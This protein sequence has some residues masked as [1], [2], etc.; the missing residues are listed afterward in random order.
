ML[1]KIKKYVEIATVYFKDVFERD[2]IG[3]IK[4]FVPA[5]VYFM[6]NYYIFVSQFD[7]AEFK[8][9]NNSVPNLEHFKPLIA[10]L[11]KSIE[12]MNL[13]HN[14]FNFSQ[15][16]IGAGTTN[17]EKMAK[18]N[19]KTPKKKMLAHLEAW[20]GETGEKAVSKALMALK[21]N[22]NI[23]FDKIMKMHGIND[24][25]NGLISSVFVSQIEKLF[26]YY[27]RHRNK[28]LPESA[29]SEKRKMI[30][31]DKIQIN[32]SDKFM[33]LDIKFGLCDFESFAKT[34]AT[35]IEGIDAVDV[36]IFSLLRKEKVSLREGRDE[37]VIHNDKILLRQSLKKKIKEISALV[38]E[39]LHCNI[40]KKT[41]NFEAK[42]IIPI[43]QSLNEAEKIIVKEMSTIRENLK[44]QTENARALSEVVEE[45]TGPSTAPCILHFISD[46]K[47]LSF[48][49]AKKKL[50][51]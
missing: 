10:E 12:V 37:K 17:L 5:Y 9:S 45:L 39:D 16:K 6:K 26:K 51:T 22:I 49:E 41:I 38:G 18:W 50:I 29:I 46:T 43:I 34:F 25:S 48:E 11:N 20:T 23:F 36:D 42:E 13:A 4:K 19:E 3:P 21:G 44:L 2:E 27:I 8:K 14:A 47:G 32:F 1:D 24:Y 15:I 28:Y 40:I 30:F 31:G 7:I 33:K 35:I